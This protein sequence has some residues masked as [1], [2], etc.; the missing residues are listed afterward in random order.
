MPRTN[1]KT[2]YY[3][4]TNNGECFYVDTLAEAL[5]E[6]LGDD[7]YRLTLTAGDNELIIRRT[8]H[9]DDGIIPSEKVS[10]AGLTFRKK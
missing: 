5:A 4:R 2:A 7:G 1:E 10:A 6:F 8:S 3:I 9:W